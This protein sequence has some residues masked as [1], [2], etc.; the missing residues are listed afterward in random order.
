MAVLLVCSHAA[1]ADDHVVSL[2]DLQRQLR[3]T[4][5]QR[6]ANQTDLVRVLSLPAAKA[7]FAKYNITQNQ[8]TAAVASLDDSELARLA[9]RARTAE[10]DVEGGLIVG[11]LALIG[12]VVVIIIV[13]S[14][15]SEA[16]PPPSPSDEVYAS[17]GNGGVKGWAASAQ[18]AAI[19]G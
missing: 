7:E 13:V 19:H 3:T 2:K 18:I 6:T 5:E 15:V 8:V 16:A 14:I 9:D 12:L 1:L 17:T 10:K 11:L 4:A